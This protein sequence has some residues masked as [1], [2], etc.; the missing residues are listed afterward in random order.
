MVV[1]HQFDSQVSGRVVLPN[2]FVLFQESL[3][4]SNASLYFMPMIDMYMAE[5][6]LG[7]LLA[8]V[9]LDDLMEQLLNASSIFKYSRNHRDAEKLGQLVD[10]NPIPS[11][12]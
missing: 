4:V 5:L 8:F 1:F 9:C 11:I 6:W 3:D 2:I 7:V 10:M 12:F